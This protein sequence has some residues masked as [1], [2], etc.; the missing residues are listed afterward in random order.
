[1]TL[2]PD[3]HDDGTNVACVPSGAGFRF[4]YGPGSFARHRAEARRLGLPWRVVRDPELTWDVDVPGDIPAGLGPT[5]PAR[6]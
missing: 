5:G 2:V 6:Q 4:H 1:M 3:R